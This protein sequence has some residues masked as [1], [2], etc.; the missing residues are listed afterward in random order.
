MASQYRLMRARLLSAK[1][2]LALGIWAALNL[3]LFSQTAEQRQPPAARW[4]KDIRAFEAADQTNPPP[5]E[6]ILFIGSS[7]CCSWTSSRRC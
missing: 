4:E 7:S 5:S 1:A 6:A 3:A 2:W